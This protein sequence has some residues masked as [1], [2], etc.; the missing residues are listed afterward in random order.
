MFKEFAQGL[1]I[2]FKHLSPK[3]TTTV[4]YPAQKL[5]PSD[6]FRGLHR[7][8]LQHDREKCVA[9]YLCPTVCPAKC[10]TVESAENDKGEKYPKVYKIDLLRCIFCGYC[11]EACP[12]EAIEMTGNYELANYKREDFEFTKERLLK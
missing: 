1:W 8:V 7:L 2:T 4:E 6:R 5:Q 9:C 11:V 12:V 10:I 3:Y